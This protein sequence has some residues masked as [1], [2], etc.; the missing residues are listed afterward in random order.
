MT[1]KKFVFIGGAKQIKEILAHVNI[2]ADQAFWKRLI[3]AVTD[4]DEKK[5]T[6]E[7]RSLIKKSELGKRIGE[8][9]FEVKA[10]EREL[11]FYVDNLYLS[12]KRCYTLA[13]SGIAAQV[14]I[15]FL[16]DKAVFRILV[17][18]MLG[19]Y[20]ATIPLNL[21]FKGRVTRAGI[22]MASLFTSGDITLD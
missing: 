16:E 14:E 17:A 11:V 4:G 20:I 13:D 22:A 6:A 18:K 15:G 9:G 21:E 12:F 7:A 19:S 5:M 3:R 1:V 2:K 8:D 10:Q